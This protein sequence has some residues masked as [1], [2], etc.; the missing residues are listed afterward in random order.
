MNYTIT[1]I[2]SILIILLIAVGIWTG[3]FEDIGRG[4]NNLHTLY[5]NSSDSS[6]DGGIVEDT[7]QD[8]DPEDSVLAVDET[9]NEVLATITAYTSSVEETD[10]TPCLSASGVDLCHNIADSMEKYGYD[11]F[12]ADGVIACPKK[13]PFGTIVGIP[14]KLDGG[15]SYYDEYIC[16]DRMNSRYDG[17]ERFDIYFGGPENR[18]KALNWG[19]QKLKVKVYF[20]Q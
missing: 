3:F 11:V 19:I 6:P 7:V 4:F 17:E 16:L 9:F 2:I 10:N 15:L 1:L 8:D 5:E 12:S 20:L 14:K 13:Y 18:Q